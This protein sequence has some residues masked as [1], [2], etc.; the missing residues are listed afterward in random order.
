M[1]FRC[2]QLVHLGQHCRAMVKPIT[3]QGPI[4]SFMDVSVEQLVDQAM[5]KAVPQGLGP[6]ASPVGLVATPQVLPMEVGGV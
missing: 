1:F 6:M 5:E 4:W 2:G 3:G